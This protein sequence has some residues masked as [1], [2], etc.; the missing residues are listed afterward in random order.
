[1]AS[2]QQVGLGLG[3]WQGESESG[4]RCPSSGGPDSDSFRPSRARM[5]LRVTV[6]RTASQDSL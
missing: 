1:M 2:L 3:V 5:V 4:L 6:E